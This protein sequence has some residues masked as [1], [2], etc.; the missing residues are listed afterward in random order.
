MSDKP[1][2]D[3]ILRHLT[4]IAMA[5]FIPLPF[6]DDVIRNHL[7]RRMVRQLAEARS[8]NLSASDV[9]IL[10]NEQGCLRSCTVGC[11]TKVLLFPIRLLL[12]WI[13]IIFRIKRVTDEI[14]GDYHRG[15]LIDYALREKMPAASAVQVDAA[16]ESACRRVDISPVSNA[17]RSVLKKN[18]SALRKGARLLWKSKPAKQGP[19][20]AQVDAAV[21]KLDADS[22]AT[23]VDQ[24]LRSSLAEIPPEHLRRLKQC[25]DD[26]LKALQSPSAQ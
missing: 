14:S 12:G 21:Q 22:S 1:P 19:S 10:S 4:Y 23:T 3:I 26:A 11:F 7:K 20:D 2:D 9:S 6:V 8:V 5:G 18:M 16:I 24:Q 13:F 15:I 25:F 17:F